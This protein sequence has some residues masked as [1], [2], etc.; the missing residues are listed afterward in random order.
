M[1]AW[2]QIHQ[3]VN[4]K[5]VYF[6]YINDTS[7]KLLKITNGSHFMRNI[8]IIRIIKYFHVEVSYL[9]W[10]STVI[11]QKK[12]AVVYNYIFLPCHFLK[13]QMHTVIYYFPQQTLPPYSL[14]S[15]LFL[16]SRCFSWSLLC[17]YFYLF[18]YYIYLYVALFHLFLKVFKICFKITEDWRIRLTYNW[19]DTSS[20]E[21][22]GKHFSSNFQNALKI[23][24]NQLFR[25][26]IAWYW[27][28]DE[29]SLLNITKI[30]SS[31]MSL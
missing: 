11:F 31:I 20:L 4:I 16:L 13:I 2:V 1:Y 17:I 5:H 23:K 26:C 19:Y 29:I 9:D 8:F 3:I 30:A 7:I 22:K 21:I 18:L 6:L 10:F 14:S 24:S 25:R 15:F 28:Q 12:Y 27:V